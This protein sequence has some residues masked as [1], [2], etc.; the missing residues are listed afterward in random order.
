MHKIFDYSIKWNHLLRIL[1]IIIN[2]RNLKA[3]LKEFKPDILVYNAGTDILDT[4]PLGHMR[5]SEV[6]SILEGLSIFIY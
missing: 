3:A 1:N 5:I 4:D 2:C 6:V